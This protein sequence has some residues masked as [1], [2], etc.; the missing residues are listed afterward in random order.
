MKFLL[1]ALPCITSS[2]SINYDA[3][4]KCGYS[5]G[6]GVRCNG[7]CHHAGTW[8][9]D[10]HATSM[11][12][13]MIHYCKDSGVVINDTELC[14]NDDFWKQISCDLTIRGTHYLGE[15]CT[16]C[17]TRTSNYC[18]YPHGPLPDRHEEEFWPTTCDCVSDGSPN[19]NYDALIKC[20]DL[21]DGVM[22]DGVCRHASTWCNDHNPSMIHYNCKDSGVMTNDTG[23]CSNDNFWKQI[24][25]DLTMGGMN[26]PGERCS[27]C[28]NGLNNYCF[29]PQ[30]LPEV[31]KSHLPTTCH[32]ISNQRIKYD[33][34][35]PCSGGMMCNGKCLPAVLWCNE[36]FSE[37]CDGV[38]TNDPDLCADDQRWKDI[39]CGDLTLEDGTHFL[40]ERCTGCRT[41]T[42]NYC[43]YPQ[44]QGSPYEDYFPTSCNC[45]RTPS[46][47]DVSTASSEDVSTASSE[48]VSTTSSEDVST[49]SSEDVST[50]SSEG[51]STAST[52]TV[53]I[54]VIIIIVMIAVVGGGVYY[55]KI[56]QKQGPSH[57]TLVATQESEMGN[58]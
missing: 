35:V 10:H 38:M 56:K 1:I 11:D 22:C 26:F 47:D 42:S 30:G 58:I 33:A 24:S 40:G 23:L 32:C 44:A 6:D 51:V 9:N 34:L 57:E 43:F 4:G 28:V 31:L 3:L 18:F 7:G 8:C 27:G 48:D 15:R 41:R 20:T 39:G 12:G 50:A 21:G 17:T 5:H 52:S 25:C 53:I 16:G 13:S 19:V 14:S 49:A 37:T 55:H 29:Y 45:V 36:K 46:S 2:Q 54:M